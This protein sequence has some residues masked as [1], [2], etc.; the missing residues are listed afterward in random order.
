[1][2]D[3]LQIVWDQITCGCEIYFPTTPKSKVIFSKSLWKI[4]WRLF[5]IKLLLASERRVIV[6][7]SLAIGLCYG[8]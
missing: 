6:G 3:L 5:G 7:W 8:R 2:E 4:C 1:M